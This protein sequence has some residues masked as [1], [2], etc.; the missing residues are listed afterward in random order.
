MMK[1][2][3]KTSGF[4]LQALGMIEVEAGAWVFMKFEL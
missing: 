1:W 4:G 2:G 3:R